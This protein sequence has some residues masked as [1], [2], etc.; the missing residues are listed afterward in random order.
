MLRENGSRF[1]L[2]NQCIMEQNQ[3]NEND[4]QIFEKKI[5]DCRAAGRVDYS[6]CV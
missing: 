6:L 1:L 4:V 5:I 3:P 2:I